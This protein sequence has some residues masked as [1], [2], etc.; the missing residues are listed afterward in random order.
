[1]ET[2]SKLNIKGYQDRERKS[3]P[4]GKIEAMFNPD[5]MSFSYRTKYQSNAFLNS[6]AKSNRYDSVQPSDLSLV[7][8]F[9]ARM[10]GNNIPLRKRL[11]DLKTLCYTPD[12]ETGEP[13]YLSVHWGRLVMGEGEQRDYEGRVKDFIVTFTA[14]ERDGTPLRAEVR[15]N[16]IED[17]SFALQSAQLS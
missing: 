14:F 10:P 5:S 15:L 1:M 4:K 7:L 11:S 3:R 2:L 9:D 16:L 8:V 6:N 12:N 13:L 17:S